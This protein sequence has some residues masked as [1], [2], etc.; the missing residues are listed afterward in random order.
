MIRRFQTYIENEPWE[1]SLR[2]ADRLLKGFCYAVMILS[3]LYF[4]G[5]CLRAWLTGAF[6]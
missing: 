3:V 2:K 4:G 6:Q 1:E 5:G